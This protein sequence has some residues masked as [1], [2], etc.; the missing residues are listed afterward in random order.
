MRSGSRKSNARRGVLR[1][2]VLAAM[3]EAVSHCPQGVA[4]DLGLARETLQRAPLVYPFL[5]PANGQPIPSAVVRLQTLQ[6]SLRHVIEDCAI[7]VGSFP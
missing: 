5:G 1:D 4:V 6:L 3:H 7:R 2:V